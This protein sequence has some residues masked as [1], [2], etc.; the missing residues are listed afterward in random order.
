M[1]TVKN[2]LGHPQRP[3]SA[4]VQPFFGAPV[5]HARFPFEYL[6]NG[7]QSH[8]K[9]ILA[10]HFA[11]ARFQPPDPPLGT[12]QPG[13]CSDKVPLT[14]C[15]MAGHAVTTRKTIAIFFT[16]IAVT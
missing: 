9:W 10:L 2:R 1:N 6:A 3:I 8:G 4:L 15:A 11:P 16:A 5:N 13:P 7:P 14:S 12:G